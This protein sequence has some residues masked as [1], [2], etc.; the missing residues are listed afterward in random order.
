M[1]LGASRII[2]KPGNPAILPE[3]IQKL[4]SEF[5]RPEMERFEIP[6]SA[7]ATMAQQR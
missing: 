5:C 4:S 1:N 6:F 3:V 2:Q 7:P